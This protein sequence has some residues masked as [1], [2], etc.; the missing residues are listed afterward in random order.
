MVEQYQEQQLISHEELE[1]LKHEAFSYE[2]LVEERL[3]NRDD[4]TTVMQEVMN[5]STKEI[6]NKIFDNYIESGDYT[7]KQIEVSNKIKNML[8]GKEYLT[9]QDSIG[10]VQEEL[11]SEM[12]PLATIFE[13]LNEQEKEMIV[14]LMELVRGLSAKLG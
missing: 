5:S 2:K 3:I 11:F 1:M 10:S 6:A 8:F 9:L 12:H 14:N 4:F 7:H 13:K